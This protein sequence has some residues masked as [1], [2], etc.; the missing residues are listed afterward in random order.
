MKLGDILRLLK[1]GYSKKEIE[2]LAENED[3]MQEPAEDPKDDPKDDPKQD[4]DK[5]D[6]YNERL[7]A[8]ESKFN[9]LTESI[10]NLNFTFKGSDKKD[11]PEEDIESILSKTFL[12]G[13]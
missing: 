11:E 5:M 7:T 1:A 6:P 3:P 10:Q 13:N 9:E 12:G 8:I 2:A 4:P